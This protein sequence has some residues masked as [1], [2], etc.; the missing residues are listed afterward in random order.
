MLTLALVMALGSLGIAYAAWTDTVTIEGTVNTGSVDLEVVRYSGTWVYKDPVPTHGI[1]VFQGWADELEAWKTE[2]LGAGAMEIASA[3]MYDGA[4][5]ATGDPNSDT[6]LAVANNIFPT[7]DS[8]WFFKADVLLHYVGTVPAAVETV[9]M[10]APYAIDRDELLL[11]NIV[12]VDPYPETND[13]TDIMGWDYTTVMPLAIHDTATVGDY[14][15]GVFIPDASIDPLGGFGPG[16]VNTY[17][18]I[19]MHECDYLLLEVIMDLPQEDKLQGLAAAWSVEVRATQWDEFDW[20]AAAENYG[21]G[22]G[23]TPPP[24]E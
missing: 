14:V 10:K 6:V 18:G 11:G 13:L 3:Y 16:R 8:Q 7:E 23:Y 1:K 15:D 17:N 9:T 22:I 5:G 12:P 4:S 20:A 21:E 2:N 24:E 19:Q